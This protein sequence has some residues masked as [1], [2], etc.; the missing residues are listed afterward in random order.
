MVWM[1]SLHKGYVESFKSGEKTIEV[2]TRIPVGLWP[3]DTIYAVQTGTNGS[4]VLEMKVRRVIRMNPDLLYRLY[5]EKIQLN[6]LAF[7]DYFKGRE[8]AFGIEMK[9]VKSLD[10]SISC[11]DM[12]VKKAPQ[13]FSA[14]PCTKKDC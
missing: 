2:R 13:W 10:G 7:S 14:I 11:R 12:G 9:E 3:D 1:I 6:Y 4:I 5:Q 8:L